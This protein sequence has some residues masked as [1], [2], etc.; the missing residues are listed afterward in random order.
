[1]FL[2][3]PGSPGHHIFVGRVESEK[4]ERA[5]LPQQI[6]GQYLARQYG[7]GIIP[8]GGRQQAE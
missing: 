3:F 5:D 7:Y 2:G 6:D 1:M 4:G 8:Q